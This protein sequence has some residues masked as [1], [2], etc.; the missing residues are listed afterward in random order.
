MTTIDLRFK[1]MLGRE[2]SILLNYIAQDKIHEYNVFFSKATSHSSLHL[3]WWVSR[4]SSRNTLSSPLYYYYCLLF[5]IDNI[6]IDNEEIKEIKVDSDAFKNVVEEYLRIKCNTIPVIYENHYWGRLLKKTIKP[7]LSV[8]NELTKRIFQLM[9]S[10]LTLWF[11]DDLPDTPI[12]L[13]DTYVFPG[14]L[15]KDRYYNG[16]LDCLISEQKKYIYF[17]P[18]LVMFKLSEYFSAYKQLRQ[19]V[20]NFMVKEDYIYINDLLYALFHKFRIRKIKIPSINVKGIDFSPVIK[21]ELFSMEEYWF[22]VESILTYRFVRNL[23]RK[24]IK[25]RCSIDWFENQLVDRGWNLG[26]NYHFPEVPN[27]GYRGLVPAKLYLSQMYPTTQE[28][29]SNV[30][31]S[32]VAVIGRGFINS[33]K[34]YAPKLHVE[35][36]PA[37][38]FQHLWEG[39]VPSPNQCYYTIFIA[40][41]ITYDESLHILK[42]VRTEV[43]NISNENLRIWVKPHPTMPED[44]LRKGFSSNWP[45]IF[46]VITCSTDDCLRNS[47]ILITG[48]SSICLEAMAFGVPVILLERPHGLQFNPIPEEIPQDIWKR[49]YTG[50]DLLNAIEYFQQRSEDDINNHR[51]MGR[52]LRDD[53]FEP[54]TKQ[55]VLKFLNLNEYKEGV[56]A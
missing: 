43:N 28:Q 35:A 42:L 33:T 39:P 23:K 21:E 40:L 34:K 51:E 37:F 8:L 38:R 50:Q 49:C 48:M 36:V 10:R 2:N 27:K 46:K 3:D 41:P 16:M 1:G 26:F 20:R 53:Y 55:G 17:V 47:D 52:D 29:E 4:A 19:S 18:T 30:L 13:I 25:V 22:S 6:V 11:R 24:E 9:C 5:L 7:S 44:T 45:E 32:T 54:V 15:D 31:P 56:N 12:T 14:Y